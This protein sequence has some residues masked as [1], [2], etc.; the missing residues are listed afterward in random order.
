MCRHRC[1]SLGGNRRRI[2]ATEVLVVLLLL[3]NRYFVLWSRYTAHICLLRRRRVV[4][5]W[6]VRAVRS[7]VWGDGAGLGIDDSSRPEPVALGGVDTGE[8][9]ENEVCDYGQAPHSEQSPEAGDEIVARVVVAIATPVVIVVVL[10][11]AVLD[12][13]PCR[14]EVRQRHEDAEHAGQPED[15][16]HADMGAR[17]YTP[18]GFVGPLRPHPERG[19]FGQVPDD[20]DYLDRHPVEG[21]TSRYA[22]ALVNGECE[23]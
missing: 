1:R 8:D 3:R 20:N 15:Q 16:V 4:R 14:E 6:G 9:E 11:G 22:V 2:E 19:E 7:D 5:Y 17:M 18:T 21:K 13:T 23:G 10:L 12:A